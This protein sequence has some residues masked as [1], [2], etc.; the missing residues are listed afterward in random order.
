MVTRKKSAEPLFTLD[1]N[2]GHAT[3]FAA[4]ATQHGTDG[5]NTLSGGAGHD[6]LYGGA[7]NDNLGGNGIDTVSYLSSPVDD[8]ATGAGVTINLDD[9]SGSG[10]DAEGDQIWEIENIV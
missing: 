3:W 1:T 2:V 10:A 6:W 4:G 7:G 8:P 9:H 5:E